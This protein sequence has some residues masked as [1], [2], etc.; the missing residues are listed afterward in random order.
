MNVWQLPVLS[1]IDCDER[2]E[3]LCL[4]YWLSIGMA[5]S[6]RNSVWVAPEQDAQL[7]TAAPLTDHGQV[8]CHTT[9][10]IA[11]IPSGYH[12]VSFKF[13]FVCLFLIV[14][15][16]H[17]CGSFKS[18]LLNTEACARL[19]RC[20][21]MGARLL[22]Y[23]LSQHVTTFRPCWCWHSLNHKQGTAG[24]WNVAPAPQTCEEE[25]RIALQSNCVF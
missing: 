3:Y 25:R 4:I 7:Q 24:M 21:C 1:P 6:F 14:V 11:P 19:W 10:A 13:F 17:P 5:A 22:S 2:K 15:I 18:L 12:L 23:F 16:L 20:A 8:F 9:D